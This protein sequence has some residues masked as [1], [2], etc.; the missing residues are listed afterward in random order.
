MKT[1]THPIGWCDDTGNMVVG[2]SKVSPGCLH[3]YA[4]VDTPAR[5]LRAGKWPG[6]GGRKVETWG[7]AAERWPVQSLVAKVKRL[8]KL[9]ICD[10]CGETWPVDALNTRFGNCLCCGPLRRIR[11]FADSNSD[12]LDDRWPAETLGDL[13]EIVRNHPTIDFLL[14]TKRPEK[15]RDRLLTVV[16]K[17]VESRMAAYHLMS[18]NSRFPAQNLWLGVSVEDQTRA[19]ERIP[20][21]LEMPAA[22]R[23]LS[24]EPLLGPVDLAQ[25]CGPGADRAGTLPGIDWVIVGGESG[26]GARPCRV[27]WIQDIVRQCARAGVPC[28]VK[29]LGVN[30]TNEHTDPPW[31]PADGKGADMNEWPDDLRVRQFPKRETPNP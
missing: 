25:V 23:F 27:E 12:W 19:L 13:A 10:R 26:D 3:C 30:S 18:P 14:L 6:A 31:F 24:C 11:L 17:C 5:V 15:F 1:L 2:C 21:L 7:P 16:D 4:A 28:Y 20:K 22:V 29:Q 8:R 9:C